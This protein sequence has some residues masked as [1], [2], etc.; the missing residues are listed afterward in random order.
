MSN[1]LPFK[2]RKEIKWIDFKFCP[3][4]N[5]KYIPTKK[6]PNKCIPCKYKKKPLL[7]D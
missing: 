7:R 3:I 1:N 2:P 6:S 5:D 4:C